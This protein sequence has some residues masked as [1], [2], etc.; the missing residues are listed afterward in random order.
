MTLRKASGFSLIEA[1]V[2]ML[3]VSLAMVP[4]VANIAN[5]QNPNS[6]TRSVSDAVKSSNR[7]MIVANSI[8]QQALSGNTSVS[9]NMSQLPPPGQTLVTPLTAYMDG[10]GRAYNKPYYY[11]WVV[12]DRSYYTNTAGQLLAANSTLLPANGMPLYVT[13]QGN[14]I[15]Y[16]TLQIFDNPN[17]TTPLL[18]LP[19]YLYRNNCSTSS[20]CDPAQQA[21]TSIVFVLDKSGSMQMGNNSDPYGLAVPG[22]TSASPFLKN[23]YVVGGNNPD[24]QI[25]I[26][27]LYNDE[28]LDVTFAMP[29][30]QEDPETP[31]SELYPY[32]GG[33]PNVSFPAHCDDRTQWN[34]TLMNK[35]FVA[36]AT[37]LRPYHIERLCGYNRD[38]PPANGNSLPIGPTRD[39]T[40]HW[41]TMIN[42]NMSRIEAL[43]NALFLFLV[44]MEHKPK[45]SVNLNL[46]MVTFSDDQQLQSALEPALNTHNGFK[47]FE[48]FR[49]RAVMINREGIGS[50]SSA[51]STQ[52]HKGMKLAADMLYANDAPQKIMIVVTD[53]EF[54][55]YTGSMLSGGTPADNPF[56]LAEAVGNGT[57]NLGGINPQHK[58]ITVFAV[59]VIGASPEQMVAI[60]S[61]TPNG[62]YFLIN[63]VSDI[64]PMF[65]QMAYQLE[66]LILIK[67]AERYQLPLQTN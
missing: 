61:V 47:R 60:S 13:P 56:R 59:G 33:V 10:S 25:R 1:A 53:G 22:G 40:A 11:R 5:I 6:N 28:T 4:V 27:D 50:I 65:D 8:M 2:V 3:F 45:L 42:Q 46:G 57:Y 64:R 30:S 15:A 43:R 35:Y 23:R 37:T 51:G 31:F 48:N 38:N 41:Q 14:R 16:A 18:A 49:Q 54:N 55:G 63:S 36:N 19:T 32:P 29:T 34:V 26:A 21:K 39:T 12:E 52:A 24:T 17:S 62:Q 7:A 9:F 67:M 20:L 44:T 58:K 66:K